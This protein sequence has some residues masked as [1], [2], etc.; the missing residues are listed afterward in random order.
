MKNT[1]TAFCLLFALVLP[2]GAFQ[3]PSEP[4]SI[5][6]SFCE[7]SEQSVLKG[8]H[9]TSPG[10]IRPFDAGE[11]V[12]RSVPD[13]FSPLPGGK[14]SL[15]VIQ[16]ENG[17]QSVYEGLD[18]T[19]VISVADRISSSDYLD[20][21]PLISSYRF[22]IR[23]ARLER[24]VN[25]L[26]LLPGLNDHT[27]PEMSSLC[28]VSKEGERFQIEENRSLPAGSYLVYA[29]VSDRIRKKGELE[30]MPYCISLYNL[31]SLQAER[32][33]DTLVQTGPVLSLQ[34]GIPLQDL[35][36]EEGCLYLGEMVLNSGTAS[37]E[38]TMED[39]FGNESSRMF[40]FTVMREK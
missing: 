26:L 24:L 4:D 14:D 27:P 19:V 32:K 20:P 38:I 10:S 25:P 11:L 33:L 1:L 23:D 5:T 36:D 34:D 30:M 28:L 18:P 35:Y 3:W 22:S 6:R 37:I 31:G 12:F 17:F 2:L 7:V 39:F 8:I 29:R 21:E 15:L 40:S 13:P 16:H 9:F